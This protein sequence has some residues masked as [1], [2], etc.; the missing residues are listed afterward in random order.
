M[1][2]NS[3]LVTGGAGY[4]GSH[5]CVE[6]LNAGFNVVVVDNLSNS[7]VE[8]LARV[9]R[10]T[11]KTLS[12]YQHDIRDKAALINIFKQ[13]A[14]TAVMHF[15]GLKAVGESCAKP[16]LYYH[17]NVYG[18]LVLTEAMAEA[19]V[20]QLVF[21][22]S[23]T[24]YGNST[25]VQYVEDFPLAAINPYG[26]TKLMVEDI[27]RDLSAAD[28]LN[29]VEN[30]WKIAL[31]RYFNP[32]GA[33]ESGLIGED[34]EGIPNNLMP[35]IAQVAIGKLPQLSIF[36]NDYP[37]P[38]GTGIRDY[39][40]V[41]DLVKGHVKALAALTGDNFQNGACK[42]YNLGAG[43]GYSVLEMVH[44][45]ERV[46]GQTI[47][48]K[49]APRRAGDLAEYFANPEL[50]LKELNWRAEKTL[51]DMIADTWLWQRNNPKGYDANC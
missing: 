44:T 16:G 8:A 20:K 31:L 34:P 24:V 7:K 3:I 32:I 14:I 38:D 29:R 23:A 41:V 40:H 10:I 12:F 4:I 11:G 22:S 30:P 1:T 27:L 49:I 15:A 36:G 45:F 2:Q 5:A 18:T 21:S 46:T 6:L 51:D 47:N 19:N 42:A 37:T 28:T 17:N 43:H 48:Y 50:A 9:Q 39:I 35:Y 26:R 33:H 25:S 13:E